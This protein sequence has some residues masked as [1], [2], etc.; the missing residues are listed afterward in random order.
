MGTKT[1]LADRYGRRNLRLTVSPRH[2]ADDTVDVQVDQGLFTA[3]PVNLRRSTL[4]A[5]LDAEPNESDYR[6]VLAENQSL[7]LKLS[8][9]L[10]ERNAARAERDAARLRVQELLSDRDSWKS[11]AEEAER[12]RDIVTKERDTIRRERDG[13]WADLQDAAEAPEDAAEEPRT[14]Q[15]QIDRS[16][17]L[18]RAG[19]VVGRLATVGVLLSD[20]EVALKWAAEWILGG[21]PV[22]RG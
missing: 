4:L 22:D 19:E 6:E 9:T 14:D 13:Y 10:R 3:G 11:R 17:A 16:W 2:D 15:D 1:H 20:P 5:A 12:E 18:E 7:G 8:A 21:E